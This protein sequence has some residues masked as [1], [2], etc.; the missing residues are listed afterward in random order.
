M[1][2]RQRVVVLMLKAGAAMWTRLGQLAADGVVRPHIE[3]RIT[4]DET[5]DAQRAMET[6]HGRGKVVLLP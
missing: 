2:S 1:T 5:A 6:G 4:L 3:R